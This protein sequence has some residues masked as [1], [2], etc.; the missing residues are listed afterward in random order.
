MLPLGKSTPLPQGTPTPVP[1]LHAKDS[2][3]LTHFEVFSGQMGTFASLWLGIARH[4]FW[5]ECGW[6]LRG[7]RRRPEPLDL[8]LMQ[9]RVVP[10]AQRPL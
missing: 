3:C 10:G 7:E 4:Q 9:A 6:R 1:P 2:C 8:N 5:A